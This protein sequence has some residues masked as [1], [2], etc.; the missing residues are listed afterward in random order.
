MEIDNFSSCWGF[1]VALKEG[2]FR[3]NITSSQL[4]SENILCLENFLDYFAKIENIM[5]R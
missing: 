3:T 1:I 4:P 5:K 2:K